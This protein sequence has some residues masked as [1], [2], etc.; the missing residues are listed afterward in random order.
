MKTL[1]FLV[2]FYSFSCNIYAQHL[3]SSKTIYIYPL[4]SV[5]KN[6]ISHVQTA[7]YSFYGFNCVVKPNL[8]VSNDIISPTKKRIDASK[9]LSKYKIP[10]NIL[11]ITESDICHDKIVLKPAKQILR[12]YGILGL[13]YRPGSV[14]VISTF[15]M[16]R[17]ATKQK[18]LERLEKVALHEIGHNLGLD[19]CKNNKLCLMNDANGT[20]AQVDRERVWLCD[21]CKKKIQ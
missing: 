11:I 2:I 9:V 7:I 4:G 10:Q 16:K 17:N 13:G 3:N 12:E 6:Y 19:H 21:N 14:C 15:R 8:P 18:I 20:I 1:F 5:S